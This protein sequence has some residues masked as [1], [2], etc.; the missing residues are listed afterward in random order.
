MGSY[1]QK[2]I[3]MLNKSYL[4]KGIAISFL[5]FLAPRLALHGQV[6][7]RSSRE[8]TWNFSEQ[9][10]QVTQASGDKGAS[11]KLTGSTGWSTDA[12][13][14]NSLRFGKTGA[15]LLAD[16]VN[17]DIENVFTI[18]C[19]LKTSPDRSSA[20]TIVVQGTEAN[21]AG[22]FQLVLDKNTGLLRFIAPALSGDMNSGM[23][24][25][26]NAWH[27]VAVTYAPGRMNFYKDGKLVSL[28]KVT[29][30]LKNGVWPLAIGAQRDMTA[31][32]GGN[33]ARLKIFNIVQS[34]VRIAE[35]YS[36]K[37]AGWDLAE[38]MGISTFQEYGNQLYGMLD[39][40]VNTYDN[41][42]VSKTGWLK[43]ATWAKD[44]VFGSVVDFS[45][46]G[47]GVYIDST[48]VNLR[49]RFT[50]AAWIKAPSKRTNARIILAK[51]TDGH[52]KSSFDLGLDAGTGKLSFH[53]PGLSGNTTSSITLDDN[54]WHHV[55]VTYTQ[56]QMKFYKDGVLAAST[57]AKG[58]VEDSGAPMAI[59]ALTDRT[60]SFTGNIS[61]VRIFG[62]ALTTDQITDLYYEKETAGWN[63]DEGAGTLVRDQ[64]DNRNNGTAK[65]TAWVAGRG[66]SFSNVISF[67]EPG[68]GIAV[69][70]AGIQLRNRF[71]VAAWVQASPSRG[72]ARVILAKGKKGSAGSFSFAL[73]EGTGNVLFKAQGLSGD[74]NS[75]FQV[76]DNIWHHVMITYGN[77]EMKFYKDRQLIRTTMVKGAVSVAAAPLSIGSSVEGDGSFGG[78]M[79]QVKIYNSVRIPD[80]VTKVVPPSGP[81]LILK[82]G[83]VFDRIQSRGF[84]VDDEHQVNANDVALCKELGFDH[85]KVL[86][87]A[88]EFIYNG[89]VRNMDFVEKVVNMVLA[90]GLP[91]VVCLHPEGKF[92]A[93]YLGTDTGFQKMLT[94]YRDFSKFIKEKWTP[95]QVAFQLMTEPFGNKDGDWNGVTRKM[96]AAVRSEMPD[97]T[98][99]LSGD[100][101]GN[102][103]AMTGMIPL[104]D[105]NMYYSFTSYEP[106]RF[107]FNTLFGG[108][109]GSHGFYKDISYMPWPTSPEIVSAR[110]NDMLSTVKDAD[111][112][113]AKEQLIE[114]GKAYFNSQWLKLRAKNVSEWNDAYGGNLHIMVAEFGTVDNI[115]STKSGGASHGVYPK[116]RIQFIHDLRQSFESV[117]MGWQ[118]WSFNEYFTILDPTVRKAYVPATM[119]IVDTSLIS[120]LGVKK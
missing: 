5:L 33:I 60:H 30:S 100:R 82:R 72:K 57:M 81:A 91:C 4:F 6:T 98:L 44:D 120:A 34:P 45:T 50:I 116:E 41:Y 94:F 48:D 93:H 112:P 105:D 92:K 16:Q 62:S 104:N 83:I 37:L 89:S 85:I 118:Y 70:S 106:Y 61:R 97:H 64:N 119:S 22:Y 53:S 47:A 115:Q 76:D 80:E 40:P 79:A 11:S 77:G 108:W 23:T 117:G 39:G 28:K 99:I 73:E 56:G 95:K 74:L 49:D 51:G 25:D 66:S 18:S 46:A 68:S 102:I 69:N 111:K 12:S 36:N 43:D 114:Y 58:T 86:L 67:D 107:G 7:P 90:T 52:S 26:D 75:G 29:G 14:G 35:S 19:W 27:Q 17:T 38:G 63:L 101:A 65:K 84:P 78:K 59:G 109:R 24:V 87:T 103:Y 55:V 88:D 32:F 54:K 2:K 3:F 15:V 71:T 9:A 96:V 8:I 42:G 21:N 110:M 113:M 1:Y 20:K 13:A 31:G 10:G